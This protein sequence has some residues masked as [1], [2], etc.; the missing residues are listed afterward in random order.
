MR[1]KP[2]ASHCVKK[3]PWLTYRPMSW[4]FFS[5]VAGGEDFQLERRGAFGQALQHQLVCRP[6]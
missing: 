1:R 4:V 6:S 3:V 5:G 2:S